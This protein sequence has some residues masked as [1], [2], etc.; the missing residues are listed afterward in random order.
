MSKSLLSQTIRETL[1]FCSVLTQGRF[2]AP[3]F[4]PIWGM[5]KCFDYQTERSFK[6]IEIR[7]SSFEEEVFLTDIDDCL[8]DW[9]SA[10]KDYVA[11]NY[12]TKMDRIPPRYEYNLGYWLN[13]DDE[14]EGHEF[15]RGFQTSEE[16]HNLP[17]FSDALEY[18]P[19]IAG[20]GF[21]FVAVSSS[22]Y[23]EGIPQ[24]RRSCLEK[25]FP[26]VFSSMFLL[27]PGSSKKHVLAM[28]PPSY[29]V[30]DHEVHA[31]AGRDCGHTSFCM[32]RT[33]GLNFCDWGTVYEKINE[34]G[35][36]I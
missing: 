17:A 13:P 32:D 11:R 6:E 30:D 19:K 18:V 33:P 8:L 36:T 35:E 34:T 27:E 26:G 29:W 1:H 23:L 2:G 9:L 16:A 3:F 28:F 7:P 14:N 24:A 12:H 10:F 21:N 15:I 20:L 22:G 25:N 5:I 4:L 31:Q